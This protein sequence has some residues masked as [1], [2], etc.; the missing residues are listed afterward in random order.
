M[1]LSRM[2]AAG[3]K[4]K[5]NDKEYTLS[6]LRLK[7]IGSLEKWAEDKILGE[8]EQKI[9]MLKKAGAELNA[10]VLLSIVDRAV[11]DSKIQTYKEK[12]M[13]GVE[14]VQKA[15]ELSLR[16]KHD[17]IEEQEI[18]NIIDNIGVDT[19]QELITSLSYT[20]EE[21]DKEIKKN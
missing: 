21:E 14:G 11:S 8:A 13:E 12:Q 15:V 7:D 6:P 5:V 16:I 3:K 18:K 2:T 17:N 20:T 19:I 10:D 9:Q 4:I 1:D